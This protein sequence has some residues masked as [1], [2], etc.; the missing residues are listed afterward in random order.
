MIVRS[1]LLSSVKFCIVAGVNCDDIDE[2]A[3]VILH[4]CDTRVS[5]CSNTARGFDCICN[6]GYK[7]TD[8]GGCLDKNECE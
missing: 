2:C 7:S 3:D 1:A 8:I 5:V 6:A 4:N